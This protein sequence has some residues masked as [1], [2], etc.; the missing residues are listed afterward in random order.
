[1]IIINFDKMNRFIIILGGICMVQVE[2]FVCR[3]KIVACD[4]QVV[5]P[6]V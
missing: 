1:M 3:Y 6:K 2:F 4:I 5:I